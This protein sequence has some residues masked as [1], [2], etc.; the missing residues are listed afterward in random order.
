MVAT[1]LGLA[2]HVTGARAALPRAMPSRK[3]PAC[4]LR[5]A[6]REGS[7]RGGL[8]AV[9]PSGRAPAPLPAPGARALMLARR[10]RLRRA[11]TRPWRCGGGPSPRRAAG[12]G[13]LTA[14][15]R[16]WREYRGDAERARRVRW[17]PGKANPGVLVRTGGLRVALLVTRSLEARAGREPSGGTRRPAC[18]LL[19][20]PRHRAAAWRL[21]WEPRHGLARDGP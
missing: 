14:T 4:A 9:L 12:L 7:A 19:C 10:G 8:A 16:S 18:C 11:R 13:C 2:C 5:G 20:A 15:R 3:V 6:V 1:P 17:Q 21:C